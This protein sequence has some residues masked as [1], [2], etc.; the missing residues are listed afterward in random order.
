M[1]PQQHEP[2]EGPANR[3]EARK[4]VKDFFDK[5]EHGKKAGHD[6]RD[7]ATRNDNMSD[8]AKGGTSDPNQ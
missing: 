3:D 2:G 8:P 1:S 5:P 4:R 6:P 7:E